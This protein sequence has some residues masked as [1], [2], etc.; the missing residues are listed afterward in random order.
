MVMTKPV[1]LLLAAALVVAGA[2]AMAA[3]L[4]RPAPPPSARPGI[5]YEAEVQRL[6]TQLQAN[7]NDVAGWKSLGAAYRAQGRYMDA[8]GAY[9]EAE[10]LKP[11]DPETTGALNEL[12]QIARTRGRHDTQGGSGGAPR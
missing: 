12:A 6:E 10:K 9:L 8:V 7:P 4:T 3:Y 1:T 2:V 11:R 5:D